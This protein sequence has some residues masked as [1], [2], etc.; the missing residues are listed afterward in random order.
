MKKGHFLLHL[1]HQI[2]PLII[3][4][5]QSTLIFNHLAERL[6]QHLFRF[7]L[8]LELLDLS[9]I[10]DVVLTHCLDQAGLVGGFQ[11]LF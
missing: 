9:H 3:A 4:R 5:Y 10:V 2:N 1:I 11:W 8:F 7:Q 6:H